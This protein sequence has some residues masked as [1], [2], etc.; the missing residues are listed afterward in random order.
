MSRDEFS[1]AVLEGIARQGLDAVSDCNQMLMCP[2]HTPP[3]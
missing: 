1:W 3:I 2:A